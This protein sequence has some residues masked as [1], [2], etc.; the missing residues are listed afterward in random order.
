MSHNPPT[1]DSTLSELEALLLAEHEALRVLDHAALDRCREAKLELD[2]RL[3]DFPK[4]QFVAA[5][6][7]QLEGIKRQA[8]ANQ[9]LL[10]HARAC[11]KSMLDLATGNHFDG[12]S[13]KNGQ[14]LNR[15]GSTTQ[16]PVRLSFRS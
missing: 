3:R 7:D 12:Y 13:G 6:R 4:E 11:V 15:S 2:Q 16:S 5:Q 10:I 1:L 8:I 9:L 14:G